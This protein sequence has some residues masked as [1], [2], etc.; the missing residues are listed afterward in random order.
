M[1]RKKPWITFLN[2]LDDYLY[3]DGW[4]VNGKYIKNRNYPEGDY[5]SVIQYLIDHCYEKDEA[6][7][8]VNDLMYEKNDTGT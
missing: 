4:Y 2:D 8:I 1:K 5:E 3:D 6:V 7:K